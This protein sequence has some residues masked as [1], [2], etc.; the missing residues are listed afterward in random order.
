MESKSLKRTVSLE[1]LSDEFE[2]CSSPE[3]DSERHP[4]AKKKGS[5][6]IHNL[7]RWWFDNAGQVAVLPKDDG[8]GYQ[9]IG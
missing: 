7:A 3:N 4:L 1:F 8:L 2:K 6:Y 5:S 9:G